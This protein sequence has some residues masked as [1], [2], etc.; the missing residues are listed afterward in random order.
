MRS[1]GALESE[2]DN[3]FRIKFEC[4]KSILGCREYGHTHQKII[5]ITI[6]VLPLLESRITLRAND[7]L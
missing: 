7:F 3:Y 5:C 6:M 4:Y 1:K 2:N